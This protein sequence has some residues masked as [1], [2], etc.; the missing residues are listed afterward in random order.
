MVGRARS[1]APHRI[2]DLVR[3]EAIPLAAVREALERVRD[4][5]RPTIGMSLARFRGGCGAPRWRPAHEFD[6]NVRTLT[7]VISEVHRE[8]RDFSHIRC[9]DWCFERHRT[10]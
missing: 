10:R 4:S 5:H 1:E 9:R 8:I 6:R 2:V 7:L 3:V